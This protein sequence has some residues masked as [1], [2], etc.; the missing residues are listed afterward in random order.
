MN[1]EKLQQ[2]LEDIG[3]NDDQIADVRSRLIVPN[4]ARFDDSI[5]LSPVKQSDNDDW[6]VRAAVAAKEIS[7][8]LENGY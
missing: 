5:G 7:Q 4:E 2:E 6:R 1:N 3:L 8:R